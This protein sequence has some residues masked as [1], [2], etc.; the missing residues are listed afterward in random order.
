VAG[1]VVTY[2]CDGTLGV[3]PV[4]ILFLLAGCFGE[5]EPGVE[6]WTDG[7]YRP[8]EVTAYEVDGQ[9]DGAATRAVATF[10]LASGGRLRLELEVA[11]NP[12]VVLRAGHWRIEGARPDSGVV[13]AESMKFL[14]GQ[15][16]GPSLG[17]RFRLDRNGGPRFRVILPL[18]PL[19][20]LVFRG[21]SKSAK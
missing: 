8:L 18:R 3:M 14:G 12:Q 10:T 11:Y 2:L 15:N 9:R 7:A 20:Q 6:E 16:Q 1:R 4:A 19:N 13:H 5:S 21:V 17:G